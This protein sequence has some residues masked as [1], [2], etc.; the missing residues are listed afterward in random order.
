MEAYHH[1]GTH[2]PVHV[3]SSLEFAG[4]RQRISEYDA[5]S[6]VAGLQIAGA[7]K[8]FERDDRI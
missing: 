8:V 2:M 6:V 4:S 3:L 7:G 1:V 5:K